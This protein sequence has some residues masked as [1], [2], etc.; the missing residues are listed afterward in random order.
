MSQ[1]S[2]TS[3]S[4]LEAAR[5]KILR[6]FEGIQEVGKRNSVNTPFVTVEEASDAVSWIER[7]GVPKLEKQLPSYRKRFT[8]VEADLAHTMNKIRAEQA[9]IVKIEKIRASPRTQGFLPEIENISVLEKK[10]GDVIK[11]IS[12]LMPGVR[13]NVDTDVKWTPT[14]EQREQLANVID[15]DHDDYSGDVLFQCIQMF[16][17]EKNRFTE[18][19]SALQERSTAQETTVQNLNATVETLEHQHRKTA[20]RIKELS[21]TVAKRDEAIKSKGHD[22]EN[23]KRNT[24]DKLNHER[25]CRAE[26]E[27]KL[28]TATDVNAKLKSTV[29]ADK[30]P[31]EKTLADL[32]E[33]KEQSTRERQT[34]AKLTDDLN[35]LKSEFASSRTY[36]STETQHL[37]DDREQ[38]RLLLEV[39]P[40][41]K[42]G[43]RPYN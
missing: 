38:D 33:M 10:L 41:R 30:G 29:D 40:I 31:Y 12:E 32:L 1:S 2:T 7:I 34:I 19:I 22:Y 14:D 16:I 4:D 28:K 15:G 20:D 26:A 11:S 9:L 27:A 3:K 8:K 24:Q 39:S 43:V 25:K 36:W 23:L 42:R 21:S 37:K 35:Q 18:E 5:N 6:L 13:S 17:Q